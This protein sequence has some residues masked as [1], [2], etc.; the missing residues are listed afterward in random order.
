M[1]S[2]GGIDP[3]TLEALFKKAFRKC[4]FFPKVSEIL[5]PLR[6]VKEAAAPEEASEAWQ[7]VLAIR[8]DHLNSDF[9]DYLRRAVSA[10]PERVQRAAR[11]AGAFQEF[12]DLDQLHIWAKKRFIESY[13]RWEEIEENQFL[14]PDGELKNALIDLAQTK[15]LPAPK[16]AR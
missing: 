9:P 8:R 13:L 6:T 3:V 12:S 5:E 4:K 14:L 2:F 16:A 11:A 1:E 7:K 15:A 10:L